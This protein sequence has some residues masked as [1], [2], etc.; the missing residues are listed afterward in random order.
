[1]IGMLDNG[2]TEAGIAVA[3]PSDARDDL[4]RLILLREIEGRGPVTGAEAMASI[5]ALVCSFDLASPGFAVLHDLR[6]AGLLDASCARPP[7]YAVTDA[8]RREAERLAARCW[9]GIRAALV[10]LNVCVGCLAPRE[11]AMLWEAPRQAP[12]GEPTRAAS[13]SAGTWTLRPTTR[14]ATSR[15]DAGPVEMPQ[16][17]W[18]VAMNSPSTP[19]TR[20]SSGRPSAVTGR[21]QDRTPRI[22]ASA[23]AGTNSDPR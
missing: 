20:P 4:L 13:S 14:S 6:D 2:R 11:P 10:E 8:G 7:R 18:P 15:P 19:G 12:N 17:P 21:A 22:A 23:T 1:M 3:A 16:G 9:P 5:A